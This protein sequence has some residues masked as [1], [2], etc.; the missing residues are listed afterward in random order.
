MA[1][2]CTQARYDRQGRRWAQEKEDKT[3]KRQVIAEFGQ[4]TYDEWKE[5]I[6]LY[7]DSNMHSSSKEKDRN[8]KVVTAERVLTMLRRM[9]TVKVSP[10]KWSDSEYFN[11]TINGRNIEGCV[12]EGRMYTKLIHPNGQQQEDYVCIRD[13]IYDRDTFKIAFKKLIMDAVMM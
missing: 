12:S 8:R 2:E 3:M 5:N 11:I 4:G 1:K 6:E 10:I 13:W 9:Q 7:L